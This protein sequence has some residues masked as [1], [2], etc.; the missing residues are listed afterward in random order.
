MFG[1]IIA[2]KYTN[3]INRPTDSKKTKQIQSRIN[4]KIFRPRHTVIKSLKS[5]DKK[6]WKQPNRKDTIPIKE[7]YWMTVAFLS[8]TMKVKRKWHKIFQVLQEKNW[9]LWIQYPRK[10]CFRNEEEIKIF[11]NEGNLKELVSSTSTSKE[12]LK[13]IL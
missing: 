12:V 7:H 6:K 8:K 1:E 4:S 5:K 3:L 9:Q 13:E 2:E 11:W 10:L